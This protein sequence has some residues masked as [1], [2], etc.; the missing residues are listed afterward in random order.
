MAIRDR[1]TT[2]GGWGDPSGGE[3]GHNLYQNRTLATMVVFK[4]FD[5]QLFVNWYSF[6]G[7]IASTV[8]SNDRRDQKLF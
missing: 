4:I 8:N 5:N 2:I 7:Q 1:V 6:G 3:T